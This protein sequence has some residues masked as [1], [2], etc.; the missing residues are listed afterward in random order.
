MN[1]EELK[2]LGEHAAA[3][4]DGSSLGHNLAIESGRWPGA[5]ED[6]SDDGDE[7]TIVSA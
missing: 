5:G 7:Q 2:K 4:G 6:D 3:V 1:H